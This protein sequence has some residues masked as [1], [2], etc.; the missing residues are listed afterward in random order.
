MGCT[1]RIVFHG[2]TLGIE[3]RISLSGESPVDSAAAVR[4]LKELGY[5]N[6]RVEGSQVSA[7]RGRWFWCGCNVGDPRRNFHRTRV[8]I[9]PGGVTMYTTVTTAFVVASDCDQ[10]VFEAEMAMLGPFLRTGAIDFAPVE[11][12]HTQRRKADLRFGLAVLGI[13]LGV[14]LY[15]IELTMKARMWEPVLVSIL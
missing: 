9:E 7:V 14:P 8:S 4:F 1:M 3:R 10:A 12:A 13:S 6:T 2:W 5:R 15:V 11:E